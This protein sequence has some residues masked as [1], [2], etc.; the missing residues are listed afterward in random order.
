M[1]FIFSLVKSQEQNAAGQSQSPPQLPSIKDQSCFVLPNGKNVDLIQSNVADS[2]LQLFSNVEKFLQNSQKLYYLQ[3]IE[4]HLSPILYWI[5]PESALFLGIRSSIRK[6]SGETDHNK[7]KGAN[8]EN[9]AVC[10]E[11]KSFY[12]MFDYM[13]IA[14]YRVRSFLLSK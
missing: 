6:I 8:I 2:G 9:N 10:S 4:Y 5:K 7:I 11:D 13:N 1:S 14:Q 12:N 3:H